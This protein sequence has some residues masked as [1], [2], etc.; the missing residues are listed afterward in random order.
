MEELVGFPRERVKN[1]R[2]DRVTVF[3]TAWRVAAGH[4]GVGGRRARCRRSDD[5][6]QTTT[7]TGRRGKSVCACGGGWAADFNGTRKPRTE[8]RR[9]RRRRTRQQSAC[10]IPVLYFSSPR[11][12]LFASGLYRE[13][14][15][16]TYMKQK[17]PADIAAGNDFHSSNRHFRD[18]TS[19][20]QYSPALADGRARYRS[21]GGI[22]I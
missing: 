16:S 10:G 8:C 12:A 6:V 20:V 4:A 3:W 9:R 17:S 18:S 15:T 19:R 2:G 13:S 21:R 5:A 22:T 11:A 1:A 7:T 14:Q